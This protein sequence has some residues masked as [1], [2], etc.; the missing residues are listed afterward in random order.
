MSI[1]S[2]GK[3]K[4]VLIGT[5]LENKLDRYKRICILDNREQEKKVI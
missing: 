3:N 5:F 4:I 1:K 2:Q